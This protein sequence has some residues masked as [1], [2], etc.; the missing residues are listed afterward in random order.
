MGENAPVVVPTKV[1]KNKIKRL[2]EKEKNLK[3]L[4]SRISDK[5]KNKRKELERDLTKTQTELNK[6][7]GKST[8]EPKTLLDADIPQ[9]EILQQPLQLTKYQ[10][11]KKA[12]T[13]GKKKVDDWKKW[14]LTASEQDPKAV[15]PA[16]DDFKKRINR[17]Y[18]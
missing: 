18:I 7:T 17:L 2:K 5:N 10:E 12:A 15:D 16:F 3:R 8:D 4:F 1:T 13:W 14:L 9:E 6:I 11:I